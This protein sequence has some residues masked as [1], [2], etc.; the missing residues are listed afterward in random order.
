MGRTNLLGL[1]SLIESEKDI[2]GMSWIK[3][4]FKHLLKSQQ[5]D[6]KLTKKASR[7]IFEQMVN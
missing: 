4:G 7:I 6:I 3:W 1:V 2:F 5:I